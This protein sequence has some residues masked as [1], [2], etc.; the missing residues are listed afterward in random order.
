MQKKLDDRELTPVRPIRR[1]GEE[2]WPAAKDQPAS[3]S[4]QASK[5]EAKTETKK[6]DPAKQDTAKQDTAKQD[7][8]QEPVKQ[9]TAKQEPAKQES[10]QKPAKQDTA[11][12]DTPTP[13]AKPDVKPQDAAQN[14]TPDKKNDK[15]FA[16]IRLGTDEGGRV[17][18]N[19]AQERQI[20]SALRKQRVDTVNVKVTIGSVAPANVRLV[21]VSSNVVEVLPQFRGYNYFATPEDI[22]IVAPSTR[23]VVA[24]IPVKLTATASRPSEERTTQTETRRTETPRAEPKTTAKTAVKDRNVTVGRGDGIPSREEILG[25]PVARGPAGTT[26]TRTYRSYQYYE[27]DD[28]DVVIVERRRPRFFRSW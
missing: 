20:T 21:A 4:G 6:E 5:T 18:V 9:E 1:V 15:G 26:V 16:S 8:K 12:Q 28:D 22:V 14:K 13:T 11:K 10:N 25:A 24:T 23:K 2:N 7:S 17:A 19:E 3:T 27:P